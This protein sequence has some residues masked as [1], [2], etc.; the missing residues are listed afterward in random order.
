MVRITE[1]LLFDMT[2]C[3]AATSENFLFAIWLPKWFSVRFSPYL[4]IKNVSVLYLV[5]VINAMCFRPTLLMGTESK[6]SFFR[7]KLNKHVRTS[8]EKSSELSEH[9]PHFRNSSDEQTNCVTCGKT[10]F[11]FRMYLLCLFFG[12][13]VNFYFSIEIVSSFN[14]SCHVHMIVLL[15]KG[16]Y[17]MWCQWLYMFESPKT[18]R[19]AVWITIT[20]TYL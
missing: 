2:C 11:A 1:T 16:F 18:S 10:R 6:N 20:I 8:G 4:F 15:Q 17:D 9:G 19:Y 12:L 14:G 3:A 13:F 7:K 5:C